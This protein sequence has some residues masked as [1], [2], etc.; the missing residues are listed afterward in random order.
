MIVN[1]DSSISQI[2]SVS[3]LTEIFSSLKATN[4]LL[5]RGQ[6]VNRPLLPKIARL[7]VDRAIPHDEIV[8]LERRMLDRFKRES[9]P[10]LQ[11]LQ[12]R[13]DWDWLAVAQHQGL[14]T[15]LL[16]W[17]SNAIAALWF[18]VST[19]PPKGSDEGALWILDVQ[20]ENEKSPNADDDIFELRRTYVF[21]PFHFDRR[22]VAQ[23]GWFSVHRYAE[24][25]SK[26]ISLES[27]TKFKTSLKRCSIQRRHF[28]ELRRQLR[29]MGVTQATLF[30]DLSGLCSEIQADVLGAQRPLP[31]I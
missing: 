20:S 2:K 9:V 19:D 12:P 22:I 29:L 17:T 6:N 13:T 11:G 26:F 31:T 1:K 23:S 16:D 3:D 5:F 24:E 18:A 7:A 10:L 4:R 27:N 15:R 25:R 14:P 30:P 8:K 28:E 21:Q